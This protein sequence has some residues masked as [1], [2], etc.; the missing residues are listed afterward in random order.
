MTL[1]VILQVPDSSCELSS[2]NLKL[3]KPIYQL[4]AQ[5]NNMDSVPSLLKHRQTMRLRSLFHRSPCPWLHLWFILAWA[6]HNCNIHTD[7]KV[8]F[9]YFAVLCL[10][11]FLHC[12]KTTIIS[13]LPRQMWNTLVKAYAWAWTTVTAFPRS[14]GMKRNVSK[15]KISRRFSQSYWKIAKTDISLHFSKANVHTCLFMHLNNG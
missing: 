1:N 7:S 4:R 8:Y 13:C 9:F 15:E 6:T 3:A 5:Y 12:I 2:K 11:Q 14:H 10:W